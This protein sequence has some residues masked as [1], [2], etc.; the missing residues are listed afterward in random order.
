MLV[1][2]FPM[3]CLLLLSSDLIAAEMTLCVDPSQMSKVQSPRRIDD[4]KSLSSCQLISAITWHGWHQMLLRT[5]THRGQRGAE[6][7]MIL[8]MMTLLSVQQSIRLPLL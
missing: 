7:Y 2:M 5:T 1:S 4:K 3:R 6:E 8:P